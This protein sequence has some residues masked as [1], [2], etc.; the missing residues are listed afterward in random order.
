M[1]TKRHRPPFTV[2]KQTQHTQAWKGEQK[3]NVC[4]RERRG[5]LLSITR[6]PAEMMRSNG[7][8]ATLRGQ[9]WRRRFLTVPPF[10]Q[11]IPNLHQEKGY[12]YQGQE[13]RAL[14]SCPKSEEGNSLGVWEELGV[15][16][17]LTGGNSPIG[18]LEACIPL[19]PPFATASHWKDIFK[20]NLSFLF[21]ALPVK[22]LKVIS[23]P[24]LSNGT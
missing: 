5:S 14:L 23:Y 12:I 20:K 13:R 21:C 16:Y 1:P 3:N 18:R 7:P 24:C 19:F 8:L 6:V 22:K 15:D 17:C 2:C 10:P 11:Q 4:L 9:K